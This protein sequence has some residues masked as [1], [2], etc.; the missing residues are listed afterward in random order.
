MA[1]VRSRD[2][3]PELMVRRALHARGFRYRLHSKELPGSPDIVLPKWRT[4]VLVN[5]CFWHGHG[6]GYSRLP[7]S[8]MERW[9][10]KIAQNVARDRKVTRALSGDGWTVITVWTCE[11]R[12]AGKRGEQGLFDRLAGRIRCQERPAKTAWQC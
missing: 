4:I 11:I 1:A 12:K 2:T 5:G 8:N 10:A 6:C 3:Q 7:G 9:A